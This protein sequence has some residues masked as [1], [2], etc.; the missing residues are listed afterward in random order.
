MAK[1]RGITYHQPKIDK[2]CCQKL[3]FGTKID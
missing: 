2:D 1:G 3:K